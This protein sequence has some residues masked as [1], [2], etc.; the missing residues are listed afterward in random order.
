VPLSIWPSISAG[1]V[2]LR[3][4]VAV[5]SSDYE[6]QG[7]GQVYAMQLPRSRGDRLLLYVHASKG[8]HA[9]YPDMQKAG[10]S[11]RGYFGP[12]LYDLRL[13]GFCSLKI[14]GK[15][16]LLRTKAIIPRTGEMSIN[17]RTT[18]HTA[19]R[20]QLIDGETA[21]PIA[22]YTWEDA[23]PISGDHLFAR[24]RWRERDDVAELAGRPIRIEIAMREA[25][26]FAIRVEGQVFVGHTPAETL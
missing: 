13:D 18:E 12:L 25:E 11:T 7:G 10:I 2:P 16:G 15:D 3:Q 6:L 21:Q 5:I 26:F 17:V 1:I 9:A 20:V 24:P 8:E 22:G 23:L 19:A 4:A 14:S